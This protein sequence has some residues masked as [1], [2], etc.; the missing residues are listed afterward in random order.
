MPNFA[1]LSLFIGKIFPKKFPFF[2]HLFTP[3]LFREAQCTTGGKFRQRGTDTA[4]RSTPVLP[5]RQDRY[6]PQ[7]I[8]ADEDKQTGRRN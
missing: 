4:A 6:V 3:L 2:I 8:R 5:T 1:R 7:G